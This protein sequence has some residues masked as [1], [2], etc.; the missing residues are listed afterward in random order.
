MLKSSEALADYIGS[1]LRLELAAS[2]RTRLGY[3]LAKPAFAS[4]RRRIDWS[5]YGAAPLLGVRGGC[6]I[7]HGRSNTKAFKNAVL[8]AA[9]FAAA[10]LHSKI[11]E[12]V[13][14]LHAQEDRILTRDAP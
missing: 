10:G 5:E 3:L 2:F 8:R 7:G 4:F 14:E 6:L 12:K 1:L 13:A 11:Q 9:E